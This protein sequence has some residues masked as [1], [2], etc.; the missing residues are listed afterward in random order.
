VFILHRQSDAFCEFEVALLSLHWM[1]LFCLAVWCVFFL[2]LT[3]SLKDLPLIGLLLIALASYFIGY[4]P[5][6]RGMDAIV[7]FAGVT[8]GKGAS[9]FLSGS[10]RRE[11]ALTKN[12]ESD[13]S[14]LTSAAA[15]LIGLVML[16][17]FSSW[18]HL[19][20]TNNFYNGPRWMGLWN[21]PNIYGI[22]ME[23]GVVLAIGLLAA[24]AKLKIKNAKTNWFLGIAVFMLGVGL[25]M[26]YSRGAWVG[27]AV[28]LLYLSWCY[29][30]L[31]WRWVLPGFFV[32]AAVVVVFWHSTSDNGPW[33][34]KRLDFSRPSA[35]HRVSAWRGAVRMMRDHPL[36]VGWN[37]AVA[38]YEKNY[39][40]PADGAAAIITND[41]L[42]LGTQL[43]IA[44][45]LCFVTYC[46]LC[47]RGKGRMENEEGRI[48][49][50]CCAGALALLVAFWFD[51]GLFDLPTTVVFWV[52]L[53]LGAERKVDRGELMVDRPKTV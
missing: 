11:S 26:S 50:A 1:L 5:S 47:L 53:E 19:D 17:T 49:A 8:L 35:Q 43:G 39:S 10:S 31:K 45:L 24:N 9:L 38:T 48:Q 29:G 13:Q 51:G 23:A 46:A 44:A 7:F 4:A 16:L 14:G 18:W 32:A 2:F 25:V 3:F 15:F 21:S 33:Y 27:T 20:M 6:W 30:K 12:P 22:L 28:G 34:L 36:G 40:P 41:Y 42:M 52:L 37:H